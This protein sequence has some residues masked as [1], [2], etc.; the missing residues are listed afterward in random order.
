[1][2]AAG[3]L[4]CAPAYGTGF[5]IVGGPS[6]TSSQRF[7]KAAFASLF[8]EAPAGDRQ[9]G[10]IATLGW[11]DARHTQRDD[12]DHEVFLVAGGARFVTRSQRWFVSE[13]LA[14]TSTRTDALSSRLEFMTS[15]GWQRGHF[16]VLLRHVSN[17]HALGGGKNL[18]E[19]MLLAGVRW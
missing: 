11:I 15:A 8:G 5:D 12:L 6:V 7:T 3:L 1:M 10:P 9:I 4:A 2:L 13:Q 16:I 19:T 18:G 14:A 17:A